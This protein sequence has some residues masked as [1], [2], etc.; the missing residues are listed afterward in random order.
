MMLARRGMEVDV[1]EKREKPTNQLA[2][3][4]HSYPMMLSQRSRRA[5]EAAGA[6]PAC[7]AA[8]SPTVQGIVS[9]ASGKTF[10]RPRASY[11]V[12]RVGL[13]SDLVDVASAQP[14]ITFHFGHSLQQ[15]DFARQAAVLEGEGG[16]V[17]ARYDLLVAAD[18][19]NSTARGLLQAADPEL[20]VAE[21]FRPEKS[22]YLTFHGVAAPP[23]IPAEHGARQWLYMIGDA[24]RQGRAS[25]TMWR[26]E[27]G[28]ISGMLVQPANF[29]Q[30]QQEAL[31][32]SAFPQ[33]P[34]GF[35]REVAAQT[36]TGN[37]AVSVFGHICQCSKFHSGRVIL[38]GDSAHAVTS[39]LGQGCNTALES[40]AVLNS[41]LDRTSSIEEAAAAFTA[42][43]LPDAHALQDLEYMLA[44][45]ANTRRRYGSFL[46]RAYAAVLGEEGK[47]L[48]PVGTDVCC[49]KL[50]AAEAVALSFDAQLLV[51]AR[52]GA[53]DVHLLHAL[54]ENHSTLPLATWHLPDG[55]ALRQFAWRPSQPQGQEPPQCAVLTTDGALLTGCLCAPLKATEQDVGTVAWS[56][57]GAMLAF[58]MG[59]C[60]TVRDAASGRSFTTRI[61]SGEL[62]SVPE[63]QEAVE[64]AVDSLVWVGASALLVGG[65]LFMPGSDGAE[66]EE[67]GEAPL[68]VLQWA[69]WQAGQRP[70]GLQIAEFFAANVAPESAPPGTGPYLFAACV[71]AWGAVAAAHRKANDEHVKL[72]EAGAGPPR[73]L[74][75]TEEWSAIRIP[76]APDDADNFV[77]GLAVD[78]TCMDLPVA[79]AATA[80]PSED[81]LDE[82]GEDSG[83]G[84]E[85]GSA[86]DADERAEGDGEEV[87][88]RR[89]GRPAAG[90]APGAGAR[91]E[92]VA[93]QEEDDEDEVQSRRQ[94]ESTATPGEEALSRPQ[95]A[96]AR[97]S[98]P[99]A[100]GGALAARGVQAHEPVVRDKEPQLQGEGAE[101]A[102]MEADFLRSLGETRRME[103]AFRRAITSAEGTDSG[104]KTLDLAD[105]PDSP[106]LHTRLGFARGT[107]RRTAGLVS[108]AEDVSQ[109]IETARRRFAE[110]CQGCREDRLRSE[111]LLRFR[112]GEAATVQGA[113]ALEPG[114][115]AAVDSAEATC[116]VLRRQAADLLDCLQE[117]EERTRLHGAASAQRATSLQLYSAV[118][119]QA[120]VARAEL[121]RLEALQERLESLGLSCAEDDG[122]LVGL[123][124]TASPADPRT[125]SKSG[126]HSATKGSVP[127]SR[128]GWP[129]AAA[130]TAKDGGSSSAAGAWT[131]GNAAHLRSL[132]LSKAA[133]GR[134]LRVTAGGPSTQAREPA[135]GSAH[136]PSLPQPGARGE[137][138]STAAAPAAS[139]T[140]HKRPHPRPDLDDGED[141]SATSAAGR[142]P[143]ARARRDGPRAALA[144]DGPAEPA[145][146]EGSSQASAP[147]AAPPPPQPP[148]RRLV[149]RAG[150]PAAGPLAS[151]PLPA[152]AP[153][154]AAAPAAGQAPQPPTAALL[155][156]SGAGGGSAGEA[157]GPPA[158]PAHAS[159]GR[160]ASAR[161]S[162]GASTAA[163]SAPAPATVQAPP[164][165]A[166]P[167][168]GGK[169]AGHPAPAAST[170]L[171][172]GSGLNLF[173]GASTP[174]PAGGVATAAALSGFGFG[175]N[176]PALASL[177][178]A[179]SSQPQATPAASA[180]GGSPVF[181][182]NAFT[183]GGAPP[184]SSTPPANV[185]GRSLGFGS[186]PAP[187]SAPAFGQ[188]AA[189][190][191]GGFF[192]SSAPAPAPGSAFGAPA[193]QPAGG[194]FGGGLFGGGAAAAPA[195]PAGFGSSPLASGFGQPS[196][197]G[198][199]LPARPAFGQPATPGFGTPATPGFGT[200]AT[201]GFGAPSAPG[202]GAPAAPSTPTQTFGSFGSTGGSGG[203][204]AAFGGGGSA[205]SPFGQAAQVGGG[206]AAAAQAGGGFGAAAQQGG[207][208]G[209]AAQQGGGFGAAAQQGGGFGAAAQ[210]GGG[211]GGFGS[212]G[213]FG[214]GGSPTPPPNTAANSAMWQMRK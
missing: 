20:S 49:C 104:D 129:A 28:R 142:S 175:V 106:A 212:A 178:A 159:A 127:R 146:S 48:M 121:A 191:A 50:P 154:A 180:A 137:L 97:P 86:P 208:F 31:L 179:A 34:D 92:S 195:A 111:A 206:F 125:G 134:R 133:V 56:D 81:E 183:L 73:S 21:R 59:E 44:C 57:D 114:L 187:G 145:A 110:L 200:P 193:L 24:Q 37:Q 43:R 213:G 38:L 136:A 79:A 65:R 67:Q 122:E 194:L 184:P 144:G 211:F 188:P 60:V 30:A 63:G 46:L 88:S 113:V 29:E 152:G 201:P 102:A 162:S 160:L 35:R 61:M 62:Q 189:A 147:G 82:G 148:R 168:A 209:A 99:R 214:L 5:L 11:L 95:P 39:T 210:Q 118:N 12:H 66:E 70:Q 42:A 163:G 91:S 120:A 10:V 165:P 108:R 1:Y 19:A 158:R 119:A 107:R 18:G 7:C 135:S 192:D 116:A 64:L 87:S 176:A 41:V 3:S 77:L 103:A 198:F 170:A 174:L 71:A 45:S 204:F 14:G 203:G 54:I 100:P 172:C 90:R 181:A 123:P 85:A 112:G 74:D 131:S 186:A 68:A 207:G 115:A 13:A 109:A 76:Y 16:R 151:G 84:S 130:G 171:A 78:L 155:M 196:V 132:L 23:Q 4:L 128:L 98:D 143:P 6:E 156:R 83:D 47:D 22:G 157:A 167:A 17:E 197:P 185:F 53:L 153:P 117:R 26:D 2:A 177:A 52:G 89:D 138:W 69:A 166:P 94:G 169:Q 27:H 72:Y 182:M 96:P 33:L 105:E 8:S 173:G 80:L 126:W 58:A 202:F 199:G 93:G 150:I 51:C 124:R 149:P 36:C 40:C 190:P 101:V 55:A 140:A 164:L 15:I 205:G 25:S 141:V 139:P 161:S 9:L 32:A 75:V